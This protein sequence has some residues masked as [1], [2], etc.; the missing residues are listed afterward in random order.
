MYICVCVC[1]CV[2]DL[3]FNKVEAISTL[4][5]KLL[6]SIDQFTYPISNI[7]S[8]DVYICLGKVWDA[9][10]RLSIILKSDLLDKIK[11][12]FFQA[13]AVLVLLFSGTTWSL[14]KCS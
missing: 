13:M 9:I 8:T 2:C 3:Y 7:S 4:K 10:D 11:R 12:D 1:V 5:G 6:K 14:M